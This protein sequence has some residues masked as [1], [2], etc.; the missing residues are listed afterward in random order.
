MKLS[1]ETKQDFLKNINLIARGNHETVGT[2]RA[3]QLSGF[4][5]IE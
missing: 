3:A 2:T 4:W 1:T 5:V